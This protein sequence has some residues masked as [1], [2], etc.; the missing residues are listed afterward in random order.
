MDVELTTILPHSVGTWNNGYTNPTPNELP[1]MGIGTPNGVQSF[2]KEVLTLFK[3]CGM[4]I[5]E[6]ILSYSTSAINNYQGAI[7]SSLDNAKEVGIKLMVRILSNKITIDL[8]YD[9]SD[10][11]LLTPSM[12]YERWLKTVQAQVK[13]VS[14]TN[15][16]WT[17][18]LYSPWELLVSRI[19]KP[20]NG[21]D[22]KSA[23][24][25]WMF[26]DEPAL[27]MFWVYSQLKANLQNYYKDNNLGSSYLFYVNLFK[28][29]FTKREAGNR[30]SGNMNELP[31]TGIVTGFDRIY[32]YSS[33]LDQFVNLF[34]PEVLSFDAYPEDLR[35]WGIRNNTIDFFNSLIAFNKRRIE[36]AIPFWS[37]VLS[38]S[39]MDN[40][41][42]V[43]TPTLASLK[44]QAYMA[45]A[46]GAQGLAFWRIGQDNETNADGSP[47]HPNAPIASDGSKTATFT[48]VKSLTQQIKKY[49]DLFINASPIKTRFTAIPP[50]TRVAETGVIGIDPAY[51]ETSNI[52]IVSQ[53]LYQ[54]AGVLISR[55]RAPGK[56]FTVIVNLDPYNTQ[57][58]RLKLTNSV[59]D[60]TDN[61]R[62]LNA[63]SPL[64][65]VLG[66][67]DWRILTDAGFIITPQ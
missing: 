4:N 18:K 15:E 55:F 60:V 32:E 29:D 7:F 52:G 37:T 45:L 53:V 41:T 13:L 57:T 61:S 8:P 30:L 26:Q 23:V 34:N 16:E 3:E 44:Y 12:V 14:P 31:N 39:I 25:G 40:T 20:T 17:D 9:P 67:S 48:M 51:I 49:Q 2:S 38:S 33:Y 11:P 66:P 24:A 19:M 28:D 1:M 21:K 10:Y 47:K 43:C 65:F 64:T 56:Y 35:Y 5:A 54:E 63:S 62:L 6:N 22:Y 42:P 36:N 27:S 50:F 59:Y 58:I 46:F